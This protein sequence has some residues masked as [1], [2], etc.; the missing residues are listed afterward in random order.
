M[1]EVQRM[2]GAQEEMR[3]ERQRGARSCEKFRL[4]PEG[5]GEL[6]QGLEQE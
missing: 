1:A 6:L 4:Y 2:R 5:P 3:L